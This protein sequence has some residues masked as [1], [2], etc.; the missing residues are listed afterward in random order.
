MKDADRWRAMVLLSAVELNLSEL[1][2]I[3]SWW[4]SIGPGSRHRLL[5]FQ[6]EV[7]AYQH[8]LQNLQTGKLTLDQA[9]DRDGG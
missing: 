9:V 8:E 5:E 7:R 2:S 6:G 4:G 3:D 1:H